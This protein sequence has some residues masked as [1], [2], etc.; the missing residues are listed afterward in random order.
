[1]VEDTM[2]LA[3][4]VEAVAEE[5]PVNQDLLVLNVV[6]MTTEPTTVP[7]EGIRRPMGLEGMPPHTRLEQV[8]QRPQLVDRPSVFVVE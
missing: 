6:P 4:E 5:A 8:D 3:E 1:M 7:S 2:G